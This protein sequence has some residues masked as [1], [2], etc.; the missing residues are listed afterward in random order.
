M[1]ESYEGFAFFCGA[2]IGGICLWFFTYLIVDALWVT[3]IHAACY[4]QKPLTFEYNGSAYAAKCDI[5][6][7]I[8]LEE[9]K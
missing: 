1:K 4:N 8:M 2:V 5:V 7:Q 6:N 3:E 9:Q